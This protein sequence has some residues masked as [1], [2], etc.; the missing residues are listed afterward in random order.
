ML[1]QKKKA[2]RQNPVAKIV[3]D[4]LKIFSPQMYLK[5]KIYKNIG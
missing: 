2:E 5:V 1:M 3:L 4:F